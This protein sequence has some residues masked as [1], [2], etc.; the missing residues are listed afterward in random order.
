VIVVT[1][2]GIVQLAKLVRAIVW[3]TPYARMSVTA[4]VIVVNLFKKIKSKKL[5]KQNKN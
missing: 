3:A 5:K 1:A 4:S 2:L